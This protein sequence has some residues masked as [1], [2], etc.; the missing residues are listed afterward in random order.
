VARLSPFTSRVI[1]PFIP[2]EIGMDS[3][4]TQDGDYVM[5]Q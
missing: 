5:L 2:D 1:I 4:T 3:V